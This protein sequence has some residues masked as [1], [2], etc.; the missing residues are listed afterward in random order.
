MSW[1]RVLLFVPPAITL[2]LGVWQV[3]RLQWKLGLI[4]HREERVQMDPV[5]LPYPVTEK[6]IT[7]LEFAPVWV[8]GTFDHSKEHLMLPRFNEGEVGAHVITP[9]TRTEGET[10]MINRGWVPRTK[11]DRATR[12]EPDVGEVTVIG[13]PRVSAK[14]KGSSFMPDNNPEKREW[15]WLDIPSM[16][17]AMG[18]QPVMLDAW[19]DKTQIANPDRPV[20]GQ[21]PISLKNDHMQY[22]I[23]W[24]S[25][26]FFLGLMCRHYIRQP[27]KVMNLSKSR[28][29]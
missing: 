3:Y 23:T 29:Y 11:Q 20:P 4:K 21:T 1:K 15:Y 7:D 25:L 10:I 14:A 24:F 19:K 18:T 6:D 12:T 8:K 22:A 17:K 26:T 2:T 28:R 13:L 5:D 16:A 27:P 9:F